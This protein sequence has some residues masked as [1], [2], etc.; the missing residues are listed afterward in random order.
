MKKPKNFF[1]D[2]VKGTGYYTPMDIAPGEFSNSMIDDLKAHNLRVLEEAY[3]PRCETKDYEEFPELDPIFAIG[4]PDI[5]RCPVCLV[6]EKFD[7]F[8]EMMHD[9]EMP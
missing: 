6:Y 3:G 8:W 7:A 1:S 2:P 4:D 5:G 9:M